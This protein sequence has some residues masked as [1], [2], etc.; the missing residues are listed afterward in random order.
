[1]E[2]VSGA[3]MKRVSGE[4]IRHDFARPIRVVRR[5]RRVPLVGPALLA[6]NA[7]APL[8]VTDLEHLIAQKT[9]SPTQDPDELAFCRQAGRSQA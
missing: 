9:F 1:V 7:Q 4:V 8:D 2:R 6:R 5:D 3:S